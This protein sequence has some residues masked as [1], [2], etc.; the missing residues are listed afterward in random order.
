MK[1]IYQSLRSKVYS[2]PVDES[3]ATRRG[4]LEAMGWT[5]TKTIGDEPAAVVSYSS[6]FVEAAKMASAAEGLPLP[7]DL[8]YRD[9][10]ISVGIPSMESLTDAL[11]GLHRIKGIGPRRAA[12]VREALG[13]K[14]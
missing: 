9:L 4:R 6:D 3:D 8:P 13:A 7:D 14:E 5:I 11:P 12:A 2:T 1:Y 10:L